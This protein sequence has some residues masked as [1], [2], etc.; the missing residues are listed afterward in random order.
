MMH[1]LRILAFLVVFLIIALA[2]GQ[3]GAF[4]ARLKLP[5]ITGF[6]LIGIVAGPYVLE[7]AATNH[8]DF[9]GKYVKTTLC[10]LPNVVG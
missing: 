6:L 9:I 4:L 7:I 1:P 3:I 10:R 2:S 5:L 8:T